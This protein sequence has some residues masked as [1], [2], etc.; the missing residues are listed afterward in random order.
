MTVNS[1]P[2]P[3]H[4]DGTVY[5][6]S[7]YRGNMLQAVD[8]S[9]GPRATSEGSD[10]V[11]WQLR[12]GHSLRRFVLVYGEQLY[13]IKHLR[14]IFSSLDAATGEHHFTARLPGIRNVYASPIAAA[15][16]VYVFD[17]GGAAVVLEHGKELKVLAQNALD[18]GIDATPAL[19]GNEMYIRGRHYLYAISTVLPAKL[20]DRMSSI[21]YQPG[22]ERTHSE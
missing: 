2:T 8:L 5:L 7:G 18:D 4:R 14:N 12:P 1:V 19:V 3:V 16:R 13:F 6:A 10:A 17:R 21:S 9:S 15:G 11:R 20:D 22:D